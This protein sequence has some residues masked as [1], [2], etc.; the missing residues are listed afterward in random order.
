MLPSFC[1]SYTNISDQTRQA[2]YQDGGTSCDDVLF[3]VTTWTRFIGASGSILANCPV[4]V[5]HCGATASGWYSGVY[6]STAGTS[7]IGTVCFNWGTN[8]CMWSTTINVIN[9]N[10]FYIFSLSAPPICDARFCTI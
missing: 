6:P 2:Y 9:C 1:T 10:G 5:R 4:P 7:V 8:T 3:S